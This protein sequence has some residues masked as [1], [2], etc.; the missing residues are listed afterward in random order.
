M[1]D[2]KYIKM[3]D[4]Q[5]CEHDVKCIYDV[6]CEPLHWF[7]HQYIKYTPLEM[8]DIAAIMHITPATLSRK[9]KISSK[10]HSPLTDE[11]IKEICEAL[12]FS[13]TSILFFYENKEIFEKKIKS[14][15]F[16]E[17]TDKLSLKS[18]NFLDFTGKSADANNIMSSISDEQ[19][20]KPD[21]LYSSDDEILSRLRG[22]WYFYFPS[23]DSSIIDGRKKNIQ[24][25]YIP[26]TD[27]PDTNELY[28]LYSEDHIYSGIFTITKNK[29]QYLADLKYLTNPQTMSVLHY[30]GDVRC[31]ANT[32]ALFATLTNKKDGDIIYM[33]LDTLSVEKD[34]KYI[35]ASVLL[36]ARNVVE[37]KHR[38]CS[39]RM[40]L[41]RKPIDR[42]S[43]AYTVMKSNLMM[44][45]SV[46]RIDDQGYN[47]LQKYRE[48]YGSMALDS[49]LQKYPSIEYITDS[50]YINVHRCAYIDESLLK[51]FKSDDM[52]DRLFLETLLRLH[53]IAPWYSKTKTSKINSLLKTFYDD[54]EL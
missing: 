34:V 53:S 8:R 4:L 7:V 48:Q 30:E 47:E 38:P 49:F 31:P 23:S 21:E 28:N 9:L 39:L 32:H 27:E 15:G 14:D 20:Q 11:N 35:M 1:S 13:L 33:I 50:N 51:S 17:L 3:L 36:L 54:N 10:E 52:N 26:Q 44:N 24:K 46:I 18:K 29:Q 5:T 25:T 19:K 42:N 37:H 40:I 12:G 41:S 45:D 2:K 22:K 16:A 43:P 6:Y